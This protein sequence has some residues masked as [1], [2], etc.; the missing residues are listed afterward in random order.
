[1]NATVVTVTGYHGSER[2]KLIK[3]ISLAGANYVG[4]ITKSTTH[5]VRIFFFFLALICIL[6]YEFQEKLKQ[7]YKEIT[8]YDL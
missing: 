3:L 4:K 1:M 8:F 5:L 6:G 7:C 2:M